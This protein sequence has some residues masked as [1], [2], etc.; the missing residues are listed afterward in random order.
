MVRRVRW[1]TVCIWV[2]GSF[3]YSYWGICSYFAF[4]YW[5]DGRG[6]IHKMNGDGTKLLD[7]Y[8]QQDEEK[9]CFFILSDEEIWPIARQ[10]I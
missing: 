10:Q 3:T 5:G 4:S 2:S 1:H 6:I 9:V 7:N 8:I